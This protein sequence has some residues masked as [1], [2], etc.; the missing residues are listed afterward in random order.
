MRHEI[1][2]VSPKGRF[3]RVF[4]IKFNE[5]LGCGAFKIVYRG[6]DND[7]GCDVAWNSINLKYLQAHDRINIT[8]ELKL[9][10]ILNHPN[11]V[12]FISA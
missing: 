2:E 9:N 1:V 4:F 5:E 8:E 7:Q 6:F 3:Y 11:I 10:R 12:H